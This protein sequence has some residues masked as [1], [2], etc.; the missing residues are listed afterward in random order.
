[1]TH[2]WSSFLLGV[3]LVGSQLRSELIFNTIG[4]GRY[5]VQTPVGLRNKANLQWAVALKAYS[6]YTLTSI[7]LPLAVVSSPGV[8]TLTLAADADGTPG[9]AIETFGITGLNATEPTIYTA[10]SVQ[11][12]RLDRD[13]QYWIVASTTNPTQV[14]W[15]NTVDSW[16]SSTSLLAYRAQGQPWSVLSDP[17]P[18][19]VI[20]RGE[21]LR[22]SSSVRFVRCSYASERSHQPLGNPNINHD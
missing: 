12:P 6:T 3:L 19:G 9:A 5:G 14:T 4:S 13:V 18:P 11:H 22:V 15:Y 8:M 17:Y 21:P 2:R 20:V 16:S 1:M 10:T 7:A